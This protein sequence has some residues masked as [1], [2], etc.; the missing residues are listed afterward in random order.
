MSIITI[1]TGQQQSHVSALQNVWTFWLCLCDRDRVKMYLRDIFLFAACR[2]HSRRGHGS[3]VCNSNKPSLVVWF[4][5]RQD[6]VH[7]LRD[8]EGFCSVENAVFQHP[9]RSFD[10]IIGVVSTD[11]KWWSEWQSP[12]GSPLI[13]CIQVV[14]VLGKSTD[15]EI[16]SWRRKLTKNSLMHVSVCFSTF[17]YWNF[18]HF[19]LIFT[20]YV[21]CFTLHDW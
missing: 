9:H 19:S 20:A 6:E 15:N 13:Q 18:I 2:P 7:K 8:V 3:L 16:R 14:K 1:R 4:K 21:V 17:H 12:Q 5:A 11:K 10:I